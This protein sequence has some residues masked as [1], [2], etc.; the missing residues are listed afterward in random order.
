MKNITI[1][2]HEDLY[3]HARLCA[4]HRNITVTELIRSF[5][6]GLETVPG[7]RART[8]QDYLVEHENTL[9]AQLIRADLTEKD[10]VSEKI[11]TPPP[12]FPVK[13]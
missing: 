8:D 6:T 13:M 12:F 3:R 5:L 7:R 4:A 1:T 10:E 11:N 9:I 2:V